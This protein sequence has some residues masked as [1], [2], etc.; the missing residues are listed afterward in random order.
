MSKSLPANVTTLSDSA[1]TGL[2]D[3]LRS[4]ALKPFQVRA[5]VR[6]LTEQIASSL[7]IRPPPDEI[8]AIIVVLRSGLAMYES[9]MKH[10]PDEA[11]VTTFHM[12]IFRDRVSLQPVEY[13]N[14]LPVKPKEVKHAYVLDPVIATGGTASA[15]VEILRYVRFLQLLQALTVPGIGASTR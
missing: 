15:V 2:L 6:Q 11:D 1:F 8:T 14:K 3:R 5:L 4:P 7:S 13:Y 12:G 10:V 9:F